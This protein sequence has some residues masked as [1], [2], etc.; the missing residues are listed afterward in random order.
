[1]DQKHHCLDRSLN[2]LRN[3]LSTALWSTASLTRQRHTN[4][5]RSHTKKL[6]LP[7]L[8][9]TRRRGAR[10]SMLFSPSTNPGKAIGHRCTLMNTDEG[11]WKF[12]RPHRRAHCTPQP[13]ATLPALVLFVS[14]RVYSWL[15]SFLFLLLHQLQNMSHEG[16]Q[17]KKPGSVFIGVHPCALR[18]SKKRKRNRRE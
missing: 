8:F 7:Q 11:R 4:E 9:L 15:K 14:I 3:S 6:T 16:T 17:F 5:N 13:L 2:P 10:T 1:M 18:F 12:S